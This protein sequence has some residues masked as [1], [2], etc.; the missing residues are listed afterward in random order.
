MKKFL[1][2]AAVAAGIAGLQAGTAMSADNC[3]FTVKGSTMS[4]NAD[5]T[6]DATILVPNG[7]TLDGKNHAITAV[8]PSGG[9]FVGAVVKNAA[10]RR[11]SRTS[12]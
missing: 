6:T 10:Q 2:L 7:F 5:C 9:H 8:D 1:V 11:T 12:R 4:L 3:S